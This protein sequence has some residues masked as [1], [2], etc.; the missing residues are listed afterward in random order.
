MAV[1]VV[2]C[3]IGSARFV[4]RRAVGQQE[5]CGRGCHGD[6]GDRIVVDCWRLGDAL[7]GAVAPSTVGDALGD[8]LGDALGAGVVG[9]ALGDSLGA[10]LGEPLGDVV[11]AKEQK[12][13]E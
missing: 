5:R 12:P 10:T 1:A 2:A 4:L 13:H 9:D 3:G 7:G 8:V 6:R 11:G